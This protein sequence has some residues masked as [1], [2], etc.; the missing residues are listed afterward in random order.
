LLL[1]LLPA[2]PPAPNNCLQALYSLDSQKSGV[3]M[4]D[5]I[6]LDVDTSPSVL[7]E[8][9]L[10]VLFQPVEPR[11]RGYVVDSDDG[12]YAV[13]ACNSRPRAALQSPAS[14]PTVPDGMHRRV[15]PWHWFPR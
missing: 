1:L 9:T 8:M 7:P 4:T 15:R 12:M 2:R 13:A 3:C 10:E 5:V 14:R 6:R 11:G